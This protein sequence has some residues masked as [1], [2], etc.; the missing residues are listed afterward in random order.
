[1]SK[2]EEPPLEWIHPEKA[3]AIWI[4]SCILIII[5]SLLF[6]AFARVPEEKVE[7]NLSSYLI[8]QAPPYMFTEHKVLASLS[9]YNPV[10]WQCDSTPDITASGKKVKEGYV[11]NNCLPFGTEVK[12]GGKSLEVQ[13][14]M[15]KRYGCEHFDILMFDIEEAKEFGRQTEEIVYYKLIE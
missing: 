6:I 7:Y 13:D 2:Q 8:A 11:A 15:N 3:M 10:W 14:R 4:V 1:M 9:A 12:I 5:A